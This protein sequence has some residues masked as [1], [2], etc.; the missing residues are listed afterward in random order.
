MRF[1]NLFLLVLFSLGLCSY[2]PTK[3]LKVMSYNIWNG[4]D[5]GKDSVR[6][7]RLINWIDKKNPD[8]VALQE[9]CGYTEEKL[10]ADAAKWG[11]PYSILL[12]TSGYPVGLTSNRPI[13]LREKVLDNLWHGMLHV[14]T[15]G[16]DFYVVHL[17][18]SKV[19]FRMKEAELISEKIK[20]ATNK[21]YI[22]LGDFNAHSP[23]DNN[24]LEKNNSLLS[25]YH[26]NKSIQQNKNLREGK[27]DYAVISKFIALPSMDVCQQYIP[28]SKRYT[29]PTPV[30]IGRNNNTLESIQNNKER[31]DYMFVSPV[32]DSAC[33]NAF[34]FN[35][36]V[37]DTLSDH[38]PIM[39]TFEF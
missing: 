17:S 5:W 30:L 18:P 1:F 3:K 36:K 8:V 35:T 14:Q 21:K 19:N 4:F 39:A 12:K 25:K 27:F 9:L 16:I 20:S 33:T 32:L 2:Q 6:Q 15:H 34:I 13:E 28:S 11:H 38:Y 22:I 31:I 26:A 23:F 37:P 29:F 24:Q 10:K 7:Q